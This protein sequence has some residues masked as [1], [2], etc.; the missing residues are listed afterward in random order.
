MKFRIVG[1]EIDSNEHTFPTHLHYIGKAK[2]LKKAVRTAGLW[3]AEMC[4][5]ATSRE[6][7]EQIQRNHP[8]SFH[9]GTCMVQIIPVEVNDL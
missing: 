7:G 4:G 2:T 8:R 5:G 6:Y 3:M 9:D 1:A